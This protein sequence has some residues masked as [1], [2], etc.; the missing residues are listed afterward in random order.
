MEFSYFTRKKDLERLDGRHFDVIIVGSGIAGAGIASLLSSNKLKVLLIDKGDFGCG[1]SSNSSKLIHGGL[2]YLAQGHILL[3]REL[4]RERNYLVKNLDIVKVLN[5]DILI[6]DDSWGKFSIYFGLFLYN[7]LGGKFAIPHFQKGKYSYPGYSGYFT[8]ED[9]ATDD[10]LLVI[11]NVVTSVMRG[12]TAINYLEAKR[13]EDKN[14]EIETIL[15]DRYGTG[16][17]KVRSKLVVNAAGPWV[18]D[19]YEIYSSRKIDNLKLTRG[20]H[21][22]I[23]KGKVEAQSAIAFR[24]YIDGRQMFIIPRGEVVIAG[25]TDD[26]TG[27]PDDLYVKDK[28]R[29]YILNSVRKIFPSIT[30]EDV[31]G[32]YVGIRPLYGKGSDPGRVT[33]DF[34]ADVTGKMITVM[35]V[36]ITNYRSASRKISKRIG[37]MLGRKLR[38]SSLPEIIY[39]REKGDEIASALRNECPLTPEDVIRRRLGYFY[40]KADQ[41]KSREEEVNKRVGDFI[42]GG[43]P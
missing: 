34:Y 36:K 2:R 26:F 6:D 42:K 32:E 29:E 37:K 38:T 12:A 14:G 28:E 41:G 24:S 13:F 40:F 21:I 10:A 7:F 31:I 15:M 8:Y 3:T 4:L 18:N 43:Q 22:I 9:A 25:T 35:G 27:R 17:Y 16:E 1:T 20:A 11:Y 5:F 33:R 39:R 30:K 19:I 23:R